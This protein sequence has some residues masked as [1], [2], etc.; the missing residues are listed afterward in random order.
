MGKEPQLRNLGQPLLFAVCETG[1]PNEYTHIW[2]YENAGDRETKRAAMQA[3]PEW[4][5]YTNASAELGAFTS[6]QNE[7]VKTVDF[8]R[9]INPNG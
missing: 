3:D 7:L 9:F 5:N 6:Q 8:Y 4:V 2:V 1:D